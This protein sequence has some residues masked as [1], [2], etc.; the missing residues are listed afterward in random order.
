MPIIDPN[1]LSR[2]IANLNSGAPAPIED[3]SAIV[4]AA[5]PTPG[6]RKFSEIYKRPATLDVMASNGLDGATL[7][8]R[9]ETNA[10][11]EAL[12]NAGIHPQQAAQFVSAASRRGMTMNDALK[13]VTATPQ[14]FGD[15]ME[16]VPNPP[17]P[18]A[19]MTWQHCGPTAPATAVAAGATVTITWQPAKP[20]AARELS[21][22]VPAN[23]TADQD[24]VAVGTITIGGVTYSNSGWVPALKYR[25]N[26][27]TVAGN[28]NFA[29]PWVAAN[30]TIS[31][32]V[33]NTN[34]VDMVNVLISMGGP[35]GG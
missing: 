1:K 12:T 17:N 22:V 32:T 30:T 2:A 20:F 28:P 21:I 13:L 26:S 15:V 6:V 24:D 10:M 9:I 11:R 18:E 34:A 5:Q 7:V 27:N 35:T 4:V 16:T 33:V 3:T 29:G 8:Q 23:A 31:V 25:P 19:A 14:R